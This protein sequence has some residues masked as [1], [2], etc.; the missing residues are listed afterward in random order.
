MRLTVFLLFLGIFGATASSYSQQNRFDLHYTGITIK[1]VFDEIRQKSDFEFFYSNDDIDV[2]RKVD[3]NVNKGSIE[4]ILD[5]ILDTKKLTYQVMDRA[6]IISNKEING[7]GSASVQQSV[8]VSGKV[9]DDSGQPLP[10]VAVV[11]KGTTNGIITDVNGKYS[12]K[13]VSQGAVLAFSFVGMTTQEIAVDGKTTIN[14][15]MKEASI[16][17]DEVVAVGYGTMKKSNVTGALTGVKEEDL[18]ERAVSNLD[19]ALA[20]QMAGVRIQQANGV[21]GEKSIIKIRGVN[22]I[23]SGTDPLYVVDGVTMSDLTSLN[24]DDVESIQVLKDASSTAIYGARGANGVILVTTKSGKKGE[25]KITFDSFVGFEQAEKKYDVMNKEEITSY[26]VWAR[27]MAYYRDKGGVSSTPWAERPST[28]QI[29]QNWIDDWD[30]DLKDLPDN[31]WQDKAFRNAFVQSYQLSV[32]GGSDKT[33]Y[34]ISGRYY[35]Q[36]GIL[37]ETGMKRT[38]FRAKIDTELNKRMRVGINLA[39]TFSAYNTSNTT[40]KESVIHHILYMMP[41]TKFD[42]QTYD[43]KMVQSFVNPIEQLKRRTDGTNS[44]DIN[45]D[46]Y[47]EIDLFKNMT[48]R[49]SFAKYLYND[50]QTL[51]YPL[52]VENGSYDYG[53]YE[54]NRSSKWQLDNT[55]TYKLKIDDHNLDFL[56]GQSCEKKHTW[57][58]YQESKGYPNSAVYTLNVATDPQ[59]ST[60]NEGEESLASYFGR[61]QY[62]YKDK[63]LLSV[64]ARYDGSSRFGSNNRWGLFPAVSAGWKMSDED[65][66]KDIAWI[67]QLKLRGSIGLSGNDNIGNYKWIGTIASANYNFNGSQVNGYRQSDFENRDFSWETTRSIDAGID[68]GAFN[69]RLQLSL[70][71]YSNTTRNILMDVPI[72]AQSGYSSV[73]KNYGKVR[74]NGFETEITGQW[75]SRE[76]KWETTV[77]VSYNKNEVLK[78]QSPFNMNYGGIYSRVE[79][80]H[81]MY[82]FYMYK[83]DGLLSE[84]DMANDN[85][86][87]VTAAEVGGRKYI[88]ANKNGKIDSDDRDWTGNPY[89]KFIYGLS[90]R[91]SYK[92]FDLSF[93]LQAQSGCDIL[94]MFA[95]QIDTGNS[96][97]TYNQL[98]RW[99]HCYKSADDPG[100]GRT[101]FP[102]AGG[103]SRWNNSDLYDASY[104]RLK[105]VT[106]GYNLPK[107]LSGRL[108]VAGL[109]LY[110]TCDNIY[111]YFFD[112]NFPGV[113]TESNTGRT[114]NGFG[115]DY[116]TYPL[117]RKFSFGVKLNF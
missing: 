68:F 42:E 106:L 28:Y 75:L 80:G 84:A 101:P 95:R 13:N 31:D 99:A 37:I 96:M 62:N 26:V 113:T 9:T 39:P 74:N 50:N 22:S 109:R 27:N 4:E 104:I 64:T 77:N 35:D 53:S 48:F 88:D 85:L 66:M 73:T 60:T 23:N 98:S 29:P 89:P 44:S 11:V 19:E 81:P 16:G 67:S 108:G 93:L 46:V 56:L 83:V 76:V 79:K 110:C 45:V 78:V 102:F 70:D 38:T 20:G 114:Y 7:W 40:D 65:F 18:K 87:K 107:S 51:F 117:A 55:L 86:P 34:F 58:S 15:V 30:N 36:D 47:G 100:D 61:I 111:T 71:Y 49:S 105:N 116:A 12:L 69:N 92:N 6:V 59:E 14:V 2:S 90:N 57:Y 54:T 3:V 97:G 41:T 24:I 94:F 17:I 32:A 1:E 91:I 10:G 33:K 52:E 21:P 115:A 103:L 5:Q 63:Y 112:K 72:P 82:A 43:T 8:T 25:P